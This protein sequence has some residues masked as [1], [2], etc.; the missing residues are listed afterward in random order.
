MKHR[1]SGG[2]FCPLCEGSVGEYDNVPV[3]YQKITRNTD[4]QK[5]FFCLKLTR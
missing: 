4:K 1:Y 5:Y 3:L 2:M